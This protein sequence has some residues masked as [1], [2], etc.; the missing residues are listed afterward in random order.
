[1]AEMFLYLPVFLLNIIIIIFIIRWR[2]F[3][4]FEGLGV[5]LLAVVITS[6]YL[7]LLIN[8]FFTPDM[9]REILALRIY[10]SI[11]HAVGLI[12]LSAGLFIINPKPAPIPRQ[13]NPRERKS[14]IKIAV[15]L[16]I[17]GF[18]MKFVSLYAE[19][20]T[21]IKSFFQNMY[22]YVIAQR[23]FGGFL[24]E[25]LAIMILGLGV[26]A[27]NQKTIKRQSIFLIIMVGLTFVLSSSRGGV[28]GPII[29]FFLSLWIFNKKLLRI[30]FNPLFISI[31]VVIIILTA[32][33]KSQIR[34]RPGAVDSSFSGMCHWGVDRFVSRFNDTG[35][36]DGYSNYINRISMD[37]S[38]LCNGKVLK[39]T[40]TSWVPHVIYKD[41]PHHPFRAI[42][43]LV[44]RDFRVSADDVSAV[45]LVGTAFADYGILSV[46]LYL[47]LYGVLLGFLRKIT[48]A[49]NANILLFIWYLHFMFI[50]GYSNF[51]H[52][53][54][55]N[56]FG[57]VALATGVIGL[58]FIYTQIL[59]IMRAAAMSAGKDYRYA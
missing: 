4:S 25:G 8:Y 57:T 58:G 13:L 22:G 29:I 27:A 3:I 52:G 39:Y 50:D 32:G 37:K 6:D 53:G 41:K 47:F 14:V 54:I 11:I 15:F 49:K 55:V 12:S 35:L 44:Y 20:I 2:G 42:G 40:L 16:V 56:I 17:L 18:T 21:S 24:D 5:A 33:L 28:V 43:D 26:I 23:K 7:G 59:F 51:I 9:T 30:W 36:Y 31:F 10:P 48:T 45:M 1:M 46:I 38:R 34:A 19:G